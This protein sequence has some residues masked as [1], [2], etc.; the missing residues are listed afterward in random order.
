MIQKDL[1]LTLERIAKYGYKEFY[2]G[3]TSDY[4]IECMKRTGGLIS[5]NDLRNYKSVEREPITFSYRGYTIHSMPPPSSGGITCFILN[6]LEN[7]DFSEFNFHSKFI[8][9]I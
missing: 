2:E 1:S 9:I 3:K 8:Y 5:R 7:V 4:I 6:Q